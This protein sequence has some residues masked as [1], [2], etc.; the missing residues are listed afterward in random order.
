MYLQCILLL[1]I[2]VLFVLSVYRTNQ[3]KQ[4]SGLTKYI[5]NS[6]VINLSET[7]EGRRRWNIIQNNYLLKNIVK[8]FPGVY[9]KTRD[10]RM[11][12]N[13]VVNTKWDIGNWLNNKS[14]IIDMSDG[15]IGVS[16]SHY[17]IWKYIVENN[18]GKVFILED[19]A[20]DISPQFNQYLDIIF[21]EVPDNW[22]II[23]LGF[24][25]HRGDTG[26]KVSNNIYRVKDFVLM[27]GYI[28]NQ[29][30]ASKLLQHLP[31]NAPLDTWISSIADDLYIYRHHFVTHVNGNQ[32]YSIMI[33]QK[34]K[35][36]Q[37]VN[38][39]NWIDLS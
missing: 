22:D 26:Y 28:I 38:T 25:L 31:I 36:K 19:D 17:N 13:I 29:K 37:I 1:I 4:T 2:L 23:L 16:I 6:F 14:R 27:H 7:T 10:K 9:G 18:M 35:E 20:I 39:N 24:W 32:P 33:N 34:R 15:E 12:D 3:H 21:K 11:Y 5:D 8:R 30:G